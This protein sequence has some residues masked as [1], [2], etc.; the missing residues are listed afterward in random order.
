MHIHGRQRQ[1]ARLD[2]TKRFAATK[3]A[4]LFATDVAARGL[5]F[6]AVDWVLQVDC[7]ED[8]KFNSVSSVTRYSQ[9][10]QLKHIFTGLVGQRDSSAMDEPFSFWI[11]VKRQLWSKD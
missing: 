11:Q 5:D 4:C 9:F 6:P 1:S 7:P 3:N 8:G 2:I 10:L